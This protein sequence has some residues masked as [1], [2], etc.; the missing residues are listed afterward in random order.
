MPGPKFTD[1]E[2]AKVVADNPTFGDYKLAGLLVGHGATQ[3]EKRRVASQLFRWR[4]RSGTN[5][6]RPPADLVVLQT[7][8]EPGEPPDDGEDRTAIEQLRLD[9]RWLRGRMAIAASDR[10]H[11]AVTGQMALVRKME[12]ELEARLAAEGEVDVQEVT[13]ERLKGLLERLGPTLLREVIGE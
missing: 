5:T 12:A 6:S 13:P 10:S 8:G 3:Q 11:T 2:L 4:K 9:I 7:P 1:D